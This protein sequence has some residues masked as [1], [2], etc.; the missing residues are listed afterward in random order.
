MIVQDLSIN[1]LNFCSML[2]LM[3]IYLVRKGEASCGNKMLGRAS[4]PPMC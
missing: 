3:D 4:D 2:G 1:K